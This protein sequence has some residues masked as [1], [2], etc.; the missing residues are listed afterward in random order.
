MY[1]TNDLGPGTSWRI[2]LYCVYVIA[3]VVADVVADVGD[4]DDL[5]VNANDVDASK[6]SNLCVILFTKSIEISSFIF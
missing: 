6:A 3:D 2:C 4:A 5:E 1:D